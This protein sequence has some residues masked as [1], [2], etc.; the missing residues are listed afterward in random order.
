[1]KIAY[2]KE[3]CLKRAP[4]EGDGNIGA[5]LFFYVKTKKSLKEESSIMFLKLR[6]MLKNQKS[7]KWFV[8][9]GATKD[10]LSIVDDGTTF[11][12]FPF[13]GE[14]GDM[15]F[16]VAM[17]NQVQEILDTYD[18]AITALDLA[19]EHLEGQATKNGF[20]GKYY[21]LKDML[22]DGRS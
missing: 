15:E 18:M 3:R 16:V 4:N 1:M 14:S 22:E 5:G 21:K 2:T 8:E 19:A 12:L 13:Y 9:H 7:E 6:E 20:W 17:R 11:G 10:G